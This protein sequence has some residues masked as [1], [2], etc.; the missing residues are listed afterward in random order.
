[1]N[2]WSENFLKF[3]KQEPALTLVLVGDT[4]SRENIRTLQE[5]G[6]GR[7]FATKVPT[8]YPGEPTGFD[9]GAFDAWQK[10]TEFPE[11]LFLRRLSEA[12]KVVVPRVAVVPD[13]V[14]R[15]LESL[16]F[17]WNW[18]GARRELPVEWPWYLA[19]QDGMTLADV[20]GVIRGGWAGLFLGGTN[21]F[22]QQTAWQ[23]V[24]LAHEFG[25]KFHY[26]RAGTL[27]KLRHAKQIGADSLDS[28]LPLW[29]KERFRTFIAEY[30]DDSQASLA[31]TH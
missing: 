4:R 7:M 6:W 15:G 2:E 28:N 13:L 5:H 8:P 1:M 12:E 19:V 31:L 18:F 10:G 25:L 21:G 20:R 3:C 29:T 30:F 17:S 22:K 11:E 24:E 14:A 23:W 26:G 27:K 9:N 16:E